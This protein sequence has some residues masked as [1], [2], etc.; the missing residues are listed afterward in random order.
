MTYDD[1]IAHWGRPSDAASALEVDRRMVDSWKERRIPSKHQ[2][3]AAALSEGKLKADDQAVA[4][5]KEIAGYMER[6]ASPE[7]AAAGSR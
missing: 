1:L 6:A 4:D 5:G 3:K 7:T 2:L